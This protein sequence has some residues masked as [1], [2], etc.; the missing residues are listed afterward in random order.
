MMLKKLLLMGCLGAALAFTA[1]DKDD[2]DPVVTEELNQA[3]LTFLNNATQGNLAEIMTGQLAATQ[4]TT[5]SVRSLGQELVTDHQA[6]QDDL[7]SIASSENVNLADT[8]DA[9]GQ[10]M[11]DVLAGLSGAAFDSA[12]INMQLTAHNTAISMYQTYSGSGTFTSLK[13]YANTYLPKL[14][15][16]AEYLDS[17]HAQLP[18]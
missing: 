2:D 18:Q 6:A 4:G 5:D 1:C 10:A 17:L 3:D 11:Y 8:V 13:N 7:D 16:H 9:N 12:F 14:Q 15:A